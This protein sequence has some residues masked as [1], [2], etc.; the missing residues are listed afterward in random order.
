[1]RRFVFT[2]GIGLCVLALFAGYGCGRHYYHQKADGEIYSLL[3]TGEHHAHLD[4]RDYH[5]APQPKSRTAHFCDM[6]KESLPKDTA[7]IVSLNKE[8]AVDLALLHSPVYQSAKENLY[9]SAVDVSK[10][11]FRFDVQFF[12]GDSV[13]YTLSGRLKGSGS[14]LQ[15]E[16]FVNAALLTATGGEIAAGLANSVTWTFN[17]KSTWS[18]DSILNIS[19]VQPLLR[20]AGRQIVLENLTQ[21]ERNFLSAMRQMAFFQ[22]GYYTQV[23][24]GSGG[25][26]APSGDSGAAYTPSPSGGFYGLLAEQIRIQ[27][28][29]QNIAGL[30]ENLNRFI[31]I[32]EAGQ[33]S[34]VSQIEETRQN[35]LEQESSFLGRMSRYETS[36]ETFV[37]SLGLPPDL[38][39]KI[40]DPLMQQFQLSSSSLADLQTDVNNVLAVIRKKDKPLPENFKTTLQKLIDQSRSEV[41]I[42]QAD[43]AALDKSVPARKADLKELEKLLKNKIEEGARIDKN[44]YDTAVFDARIKK[45]KTTDIPRNLSRINACITLIETIIKTDEAALRKQ[46]LSKTFSDS[47]IKA[48]ETLKL[49]ETSV[50]DSDEE[51]LK[52]QKELEAKQNELQSLRDAFEVP[53]EPQGDAAASSNTAVP[54]REEQKIIAELRKRD[55]YRDWI[56]RVLSAFQYEL[57]SLS[58]MQTRTRLDA[59]TLPPV[60]MSPE[61]ALKTAGDNRLDWMNRKSELAD[62]RRHIEIAADRLRG[63][64]NLTFDGKLG[65]LDEDGINFGSDTGQMMLGLEWDSPLTRHN[66]M[67]DVRKAEIAYQNVRRNYYSYVDWVNAELRS[68]LRTLQMNQVEFEI[69]RNAIFT[70]AVRVDVMQLRME[71]PPRRGDKID[72]NTASQLIGALNSFMVTQNSFLDIWVAYQTQRMLLDLNLG[73]MKLSPSGHWLDGSGTVKPDTP[74]PLP[75]PR[76]NKRYITQ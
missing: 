75:V 54:L 30:E 34:D 17:G 21:N 26:S 42:L 38:K 67:L 19:L 76:L 69:A 56:R 13:F 73:T 74:L 28:Q 72:T 11:R 37:R 59:I 62:A 36:V 46:I 70:G 22:Q 8:T 41:K 48:L 49:N 29:R 27:N 5:I 18:A 6:W 64:L 2:A 45:L 32:Y 33:V 3:H 63:N 50:L 15:H 43:L 10:E 71:Q 68:T 61:E 35:L 39:V 55:T 4:L 40:D 47:V 20:G 16:P 31:E 44:I 51:L 60:T 7:G 12:G 25:T 57:V 23:V 53:K 1:M 65:T 52:K 9:L 58:L 66:E 14:T 24:T